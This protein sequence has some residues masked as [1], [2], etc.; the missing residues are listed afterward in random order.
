MSGAAKVDNH[1]KVNKRRRKGK[2]ISLCGNE[3]GQSTI[4]S[5]LFV[6]WARTLKGLNKFC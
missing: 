4:V 5:F 1:R 2:C 3:G 6:I